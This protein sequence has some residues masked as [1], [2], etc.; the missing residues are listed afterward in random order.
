M[1]SCRACFVACAPLTLLAAVAGCNQPQRPAAASEP[2][3]IPISRPVSR[4]VTDFV[5]FTGRVNAVNTVN[6]IPRVTGYLVQ[7]P[8][9]E[10][11]EVKAGDLLFEIDPR[12]YQA[13]LNQALAQVD[14]NR[15]SLRLA[16][17]TYARDQAVATA[18]PGGVSQ[19]QLDQDLAAIEEAQARVKASQ[20][21]TEV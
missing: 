18:A 16:R 10:G 20:A 8:F 12:P 15:A 13:Q 19:Q 14:L 5:E 11:A 3:V 9:E 2:T 6:V 17:I 21:S 1:T 7:M 4:E